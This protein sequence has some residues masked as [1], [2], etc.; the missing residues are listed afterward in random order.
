METHWS[1]RNITVIK[2]ADMIIHFNWYSISIFMNI[3]S[4]CMKYLKEIVNQNK[5]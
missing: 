1:S 2:I 5:Y 3:Y 4:V